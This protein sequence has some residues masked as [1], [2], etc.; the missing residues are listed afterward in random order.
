VDNV[1]DLQQLYPQSMQDT[2][3]KGQ[4]A[5]NMDKNFVQRIMRGTPST[6]PNQLNMNGSRST[7]LMS[8]GDGYMFPSII[9]KSP[10]LGKGGF[11]KN[12]VKSGE[13]IKLPNDNMAQWLSMNYKRA[14]PE[15]FGGY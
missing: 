13:A 3:I 2:Y 8:S 5:N 14:N 11:V 9:Y 10:A 7:H 1:F 4:M 12:T 15:M 6:A